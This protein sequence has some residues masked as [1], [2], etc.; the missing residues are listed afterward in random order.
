MTSTSSLPETSFPAG[1][2]EPTQIAKDHGTEAL[3]DIA[4][5]SV[6]FD[7]A[8]LAACGLTDAPADRWLSRKGPGIPF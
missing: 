3:K 5:G 4:Y 2:I 7:I 6:R 1:S 8:A